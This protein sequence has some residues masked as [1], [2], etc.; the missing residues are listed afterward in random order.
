MRIQSIE[1]ESITFISLQRRL[2]YIS[3][4]ISYKHLFIGIQYIKLICVFLIELWLN[5]IFKNNIFS[6]SFVLCYY[7]SAVPS[8]YLPSIVVSIGE[9]I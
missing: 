4:F 2:L 9:I 7:C 3:T 5:S 1:N 6:D 8:A